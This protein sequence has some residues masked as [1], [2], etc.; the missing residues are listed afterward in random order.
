MWEADHQ[1]RAATIRRNVQRC[2][3]PLQINQKA[4]TTAE[5]HEPDANQDVDR[6]MIRAE[7]EVRDLCDTDKA[8]PQM[9]NTHE[10]G[11]LKG[12]IVQLQKEAARI[13]STLGTRTRVLAVPSPAF[14]VRADDGP[15]F[16]KY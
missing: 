11:K 7:G 16:S 13:D 14:P 12:Q 9:Y 5:D 8:A 1:A 4:G 3:A 2:N 10:F 6:S 15:A